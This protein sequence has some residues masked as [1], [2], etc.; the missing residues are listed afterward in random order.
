MGALDAPQINPDFSLQAGIYPI[1]IVLQQHV[2][3]RNGGIRLQLEHPMPVRTL[4]RMERRAGARHRRDQWL[5][6]RT[7]RKKGII[8]GHATSLLIRQGAIAALHSGR[9]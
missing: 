3:G 1:E 2:F 8:V 7:G 4:A 6:V 9:T 5:V